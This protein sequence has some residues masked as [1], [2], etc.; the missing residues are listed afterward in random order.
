MNVSPNILAKNENFKQLIQD[1][2]DGNNDT[3]I[4]LSLE[5][6]CTFLLAKEKTWKRLFN[7]NSELLQNRTA[8]QI[9]PSKTTT[10]WLFNDI[11]GYLFIACFDWKIGLF[12]QTVV[13]VY[14]IINP[15]PKPYSSWSYTSGGCFCATLPNMNEIKCIPQ[16]FLLLVPQ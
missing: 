11:W 8:K 15:I 12:Q 4:F 3:N 7:T 16:R 9:M 1:F 5:H 10:N 2:A 6:P 13:R 14:Y